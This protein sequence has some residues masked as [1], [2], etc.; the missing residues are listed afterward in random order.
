MH[1]R[2]RNYVDPVRFTELL[3]TYKLT[4]NDIILD[5]LTR[6]YFYPLAR[7]VLQKFNMRF[8][9]SEDALQEIVMQCITQIPKFDHEHPTR[10]KTSSMDPDRKAFSFFTTCA[11]H[12]VLGANRVEKSKADKIKR[13][14]REV[15]DRHSIKHGIPMNKMIVPDDDHHHHVEDLEAI[16]SEFQ[17]WEE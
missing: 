16:P 4:E 6:G 17:D 15:I 5:R 14:R 10:Y 7:G 9:D 11:K 13:Y 8:V 2:K 1:D 3:I 12:C